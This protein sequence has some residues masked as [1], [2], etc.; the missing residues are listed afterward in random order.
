MNVS[1]ERDSVPE[2]QA[3]PAPEDASVRLAAPHALAQ[4]AESWPTLHF[5]LGRA[6]H[7]LAKFFRTNVA[8]GALLSSY[9][10]PR[11]EGARARG[12]RDSGANP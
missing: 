7:Q 8:I 10:W 4:S 5:T 1:T 12:D 11:S 2:V 9:M 3:Q 6:R